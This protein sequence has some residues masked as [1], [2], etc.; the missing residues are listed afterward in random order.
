MFQ[1]QSISIDI[2]VV[3]LSSTAKE[4]ILDEWTWLVVNAMR[5]HMVTACGD[6]FIEDRLE[7]T[8]HFLDVSASELSRVT[9]TR[10]PIDRTIG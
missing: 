3:R 9:D 4:S 6:V 8:I 7:G 5:P 10:R 1:H 2:L